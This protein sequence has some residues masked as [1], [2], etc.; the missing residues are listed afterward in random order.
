MSGVLHGV[1]A[2]LKAAAAAATDAFFEY[3]TLLLN[4][5]A[6]NGAQNNTFLDSS[7]NN[8]TVTRNGDTTQG[9]FNPYMPS[10]YWSGFFDGTGDYLSTP[11]GQTP[12][13]LSNSDFTFE[14]WVYKVAGTSGTIIAGPTDNI[15]AANS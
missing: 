6:T 8:F 3:V 4:T 10:G 2:S 7:T 12:L 15:N 5:S 9:S 11:L 14:A 13:Q 1:V